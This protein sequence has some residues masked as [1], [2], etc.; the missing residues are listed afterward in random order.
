MELIQMGIREVVLRRSDFGLYEKCSL[1]KQHETWIVEK[2]EQRFEAKM[3]HC[4][5]LISGGRSS[6]FC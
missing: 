3:T 6:Y 1:Q 5:G 4:E 2:T